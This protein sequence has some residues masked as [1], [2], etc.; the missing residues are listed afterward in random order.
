MVWT[1]LGK[2]RMFESWFSASAGPAIFTM[3]AST[4]STGTFNADLSST[5]QVTLVTSGNGYEPSGFTIKRLGVDF[6]VSRDDT[7]DYAN[8][9]LRTGYQLSANGGIISNVHYFLLANDNADET[10]REVYAF[11]STGSDLDIGDGNAV[12]ITQA[13]LR[14]T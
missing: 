3:V 1:N 8:A 10:N 6:V 12:N 11:W 7:S 5:S 2:Q 9:A 13:N 4:S 14:G